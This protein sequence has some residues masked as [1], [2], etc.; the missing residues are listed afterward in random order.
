LP[1]F[2]LSYISCQFS[3]SHS[4]RWL[5]DESHANWKYK[6]SLSKDAIEHAWKESEKTLKEWVPS[7]TLSSDLTRAGGLQA[8]YTGFAPTHPGLFTVLI[9]W[10]TIHSHHKFEHSAAYG[11]FVQSI[12]PILAGNIDIVHFEITSDASTLKKTLE[13]PVTQMSH[14]FIKKG[15]VANFLT[16]FY[17][18]FEKHIVGEK[19]HGMWTSYPYEEPYILYS[20][21][22]LSV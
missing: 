15:K 1:T 8:I 6:Q 4:C 17:E 22:Q 9:I 18:S 2:I 21:L 12:F 5:I 16:A 19:Y 10:D 20:W 14:L 7:I 11:P 13:K 3:K